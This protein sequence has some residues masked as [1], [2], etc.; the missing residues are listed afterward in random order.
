[1]ALNVL[2]LQLV[3]WNVVGLIKKAEAQ[4]RQCRNS[5]L[6]GI[7]T[8]AVASVVDASNIEENVPAIVFAQ[9]RKRLDGRTSLRALSCIVN[10]DLVR[11]ARSLAVYIH[12]GWISVLPAP[13]IPRPLPPIDKP[14]T[15]QTEDRRQLLI[16]CV[17]DSP[18]ICELMKKIVTEAGYRFV[19]VTDSVRALPILL[20]KQPNMIFLD[21]VM[22]VANGY[23]VC[24]QLRRMS[25]FEATP[26]VILTGNDGVVDRVRAKMV[27]ASEFLS[28][29]V[30]RN[31]V[32]ATIE[33][34][35]LLSAPPA[36]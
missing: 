32:L 11:L 1:M 33:R 31:K 5:R 34:L 28:K 15:S 36:I 20:E 29:P 16:A 8:D 18:Q 12:K 13:D 19:S 6:A 9:L 3:S 17:D 35:L 2:R 10:V 21:L 30:D 26:I 14:A 25:A 22:P 27:K 4:Y 7:D 24:T 23:E